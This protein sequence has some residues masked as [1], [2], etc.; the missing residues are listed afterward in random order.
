MRR[1]AHQPDAGEELVDRGYWE[2]HGEHYQIIHHIG[3]QPLAESVRNVSVQRQ[4]AAKARWSKRNR[5]PTPPDDPSCKP[6]SNSQSNL[7]CGGDGT[8]RDG[9]GLRNR[10]TALSNGQQKTDDADSDAD[11]AADLRQWCEDQP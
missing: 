5:K 9:P 8:G 1:W 10:G 11:Y 6:H 7:Q 3:Y 2:D 4:N